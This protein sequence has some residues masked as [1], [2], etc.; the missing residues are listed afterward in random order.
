MKKILILIFILG[1]VVGI[2]SCNLGEKPVVKTDKEAQENIENL[3]ESIDAVSS[4]IDNINE[5]LK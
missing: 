2:S 3:T 5:N 1:F 4:S